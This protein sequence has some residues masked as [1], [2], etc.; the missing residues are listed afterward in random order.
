MEEM[1]SS[2]FDKKYVTTVQGGREVNG[3]LLKQRWDFIFFTG[4][5]A[6]GKVVMEAAS[7]HLTPVVLE[8]GGKSPCIVDE[9]ADIGI[10]ARRIVWGK[11]INAGQSCIAPDYILVHE[12][13]KEKLIEAM[14]REVRRAFGEDPS[15]SKWYPRIVNE[16]AFTRLTGYLE[17]GV[18]RFGG[19]SDAADMYIEP[20]I[21]DDVDPSSAVMQDEIFGPVLPVLTF[22]KIDEAIKFINEREKPLVFYYF[23]PGGKA[24]EMLSQTT[25]G[26]GCINDT[27][28]N[29]TNHYLPFGGVGTS[30][31][32][33]YHGKYS[34]LA[35]SNVRTIMKTPTWIDLP[36][37]YVPFRF[38]NIVKRIM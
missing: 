34:F 23:G 14:G 37:K 16:Q 17:D 29:F 10:S 20:T 24:K 31:M 35:F 26:G 21:L 4:S 5:P 15:A 27:L 22:S 12:S 25:S 6:L 1:I 33:S 2:A 28:M 13:L 19:R 32:G 11:T 18:I 9:G 38:F 36:F 3:F 30:G 7:K 8:L